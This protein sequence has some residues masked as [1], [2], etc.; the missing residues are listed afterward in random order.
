MK[1]LRLIIRAKSERGASDL[2]TLF[3]VGLAV[4]VL[5][6]G[7]LIMGW[8][9]GVKDERVLAAERHQ[10]EFNKPKKMNSL[11]KPSSRGYRVK[12]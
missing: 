7:Y 5:T 6:I 8:I 10:Y 1:T 2:D 4:T 3:L 9:K 11:E 12:Y